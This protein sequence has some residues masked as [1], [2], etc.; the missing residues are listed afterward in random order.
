MNRKMNISKRE[1]KKLRRLGKKIYGYS[2]F[3]SITFDDFAAF[4]A[5]RRTKQEILDLCIDTIP[6]VYIDMA[7]KNIP[8]FQVLSRGPLTDVGRGEGCYL[9]TKGLDV[10]LCP[11]IY[12]QV[13]EFRRIQPNVVECLMWHN[14][15]QPKSGK[16]REDM[17]FSLDPSV[18]K[19]HTV[20]PKPLRGLFQ[21]RLEEAHGRTNVS[22]DFASWRWT[23]VAKEILA[24][25]IMQFQVGGRITKYLRVPYWKTSFE[26]FHAIAA[27]KKRKGK[28][29]AEKKDKEQEEKKKKKKEQQ[30]S[31][32]YLNPLLEAIESIML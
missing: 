7:L 19:S 5:T 27:E 30:Q 13:L 10:L 31:Q 8:H 23:G 20:V 32:Q 1:L 24:F 12:S 4:D 16:K 6:D 26:S 18:V 11:W 28:E 25:Y 29:M 9:V 3:R 21:C 14:R 22:M 15:R 17:K 2:S